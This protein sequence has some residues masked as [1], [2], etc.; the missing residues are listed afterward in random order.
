MTNS[1]LSSQEVYRKLGR[2]GFGASLLGALITFLYLS[3]IDPL[4]VGEAALRTLEPVDIASFGIT[5]ALV[6]VGAYVLGS[7]LQ[8]PVRRWH[9]SI[10]S[11]TPA[12]EMPLRLAGRVLNWPLIG[13]SLIAVTWL[14]AAVFFSLFYSNPSNLIGIA[15]GGVLTTTIVYFGSDLLWRRVIPTFFPEGNLS[16][17]PTFRLWVRRRLLLA[18]ILIG[19][20]TPVLLVILTQERT[21]ALLGAPNPEA[22]LDNLILVQLFVLAVGLFAGVITAILVA[23]AIVGPLQ[24]LQE[25]MAQVARNELDTSVQ[26]TTNDELGY[27]IENFNS[28]TDG[29]RQGERLRKLF[30]LYVSAEVA[31]AAVETGAG[32]GG[33][34]VDCTV[35]FSDIRDFTVLTEQLDPERLVELINRY[36]TAMVSV[37]V[38]HGGVVTRFGGDSILAVFGTPLNPMSD[39]AD[40]A[41]HTALDMRRALSAFNDGEAAVQ[42]STLETGIG[43]ASGPVIAG[44]VGGKERI[45]YTVMGDAANLAARLEDKT[46]D[47]GYP[48][49]ISDETYRGL[50]EIPGLN[51]RP[52]SDVQIKGKRER[53][54]V[55]ALSLG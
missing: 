47:T 2:L 6:F 44:N 27:L 4:P 20:V 36:M 31:Q 54:T 23:R 17:I 18:F 1:Q 24:T 41:V 28:M 50:D 21:H 22:I 38:E 48:I 16:E 30:G 14:F 25:A 10:E 7:R 34:L 55:Y 37:I 32:L 53:V 43:I 15:I 46:K 39:H 49:L 19:G 29:L 51:A 3:V 40:R 11:G 33:E 26:V 35:M 13:S 42:Q 5:V 45:E 52:L 9:R 8:R 12:T